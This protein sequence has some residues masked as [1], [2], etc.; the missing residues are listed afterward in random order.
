MPQGP[1]G[2][3]QRAKDS[4]R[5]FPCAWQRFLPARKKELPGTGQPQVG[6]ALLPPASL[7]K[8]HLLLSPRP[9]WR[10]GSAPLSLGLKQSYCLIRLCLA[11][12]TV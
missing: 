12:I 2:P 7:T 4:A 1:R 9:A 11:K 3:A 6:L 10:R 5:G 8:Q